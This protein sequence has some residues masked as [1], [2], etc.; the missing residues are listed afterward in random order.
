MLLEFIYYILLLPNASKKHIHNIYNKIIAYYAL[1]NIII[2]NYLKKRK[3]KKSVIKKF[4][5][6]LPA[7]H[8]FME[9]IFSGGFF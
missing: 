8:L 6:L 3:H 7:H 1:C 2:K 9:Q 4:R 5:L